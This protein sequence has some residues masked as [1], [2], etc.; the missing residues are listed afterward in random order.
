MDIDRL[1][2]ESGDAWR[3][4]QPPAP[5]LESA[6][7][8]ARAPRTWAE[9]LGARRI[10]WGGMAA[11]ALLVVGSVFLALPQ[12]RPGFR[13]AD[14]PSMIGVAP[15][16]QGGRA[17]GV[18]TVVVAGGSTQLCLLEGMRLRADATPS[19]S[20]ITV[21]LTGLDP[22]RLPSPERFADVTVSENV[23]VRGTWSGDTL[24]VEDIFPAQP[25]TPPPVPCAEPAEGWPPEPSSLIEA[26]SALARLGA[27]VAAEPTVYGGV[28]TATTNGGT[29][30]LV[31]SVVG[32]VEVARTRVASVYPY[33]YCVV[34]ADF[35]L[36]ELE[37]LAATLSRPDRTWKAS[38]SA[39][40][41][42]VV[43][44]LSVLDSDA[45]RVLR[46]YPAAVPQPLVGREPE[47]D[48]SDSVN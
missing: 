4:S 39:A 45:A 9:R 12:L 47:A 32:D 31:V 26:E 42:R 43:V 37:S 40:A 30:V 18:G 6:V 16:A 25:A 7:A 29:E 22:R 21:Q 41:N 23:V 13:M 48:S 8:A 1:L 2:L 10:P 11:L 33:A 24:R 27:H 14:T 28:W 38:V 35:T 17:V 3:S 15:L 20:P 5:S 36:N 44:Q 34:A 19:C 46:N